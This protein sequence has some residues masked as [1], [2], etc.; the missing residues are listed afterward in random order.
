MEPPCAVVS[1]G[2]QSATLYPAATAAEIDDFLDISTQIWEAASSWVEPTCQS[3]TVENRAS[4]Q[5]KL[6]KLLHTLD[7]RIGDS[8][9]VVGN[10]KDVTLADIAL[11]SA[12][13]RLYQDVLGLDV[14]S[15]TPNIVRW[16]QK[17]LQHPNF[18]SI[19]GEH[20]PFFSGLIPFFSYSFVRIVPE[21]PTLF[22]P[23]T[24][25]FATVGVTRCQIACRLF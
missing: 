4:A 21:A 12:L 23:G 25:N 3:A 10:G 13:L 2:G 1:A 20:I 11:A 18:H 14:Q 7:T 22:P 6:V 15:T 9:Y 17:L 8:D 19:L 5:D 24:L 16:L